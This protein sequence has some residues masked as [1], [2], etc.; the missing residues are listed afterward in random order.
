VIDLHSH[1]LPGVDDGAETISGSLEI[2][3]SA[4]A[5]G[6]SA[7]AATPHVRPD[8]PTTPETMERL[9]EE[10]R[11]ELEQLSIP[12]GVLTGAE[13]AIDFLPRLDD[14]Q[15][16]RF[17]LGGNPGYLLI[18]TPYL[19][20]PLGMEELVLDLGARGFT[21]VLAH[22]ERNHEVQEDP[23]RMRQLVESGML[24]QLT[25]ASLD[26]RLGPAPRTTALA[27]LELGLA[28]LLAS[29]AH[30]PSVRQIGMSRAARALGDADLARWLTDDV[31]SAIVSGTS[32]PERPAAPRGR[33]GLR[34][35]LGR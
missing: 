31:P 15:L 23:A 1:L 26:G 12:L 8:Y 24:V 14:D 20:W 32:I 30:A 34:R 27:L 17:G 16:R 22:P 7:I 5:D 29:D 3:A 25:A 11:G 13:I 10:L 21:V 2:A 4:L 33:F 18:E 35:L 6:V 28:H 19:G 9:V